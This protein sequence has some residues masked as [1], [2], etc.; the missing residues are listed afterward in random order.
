MSFSFI[1]G[2]SAG[3]AIRRDGRTQPEGGGMEVVICMM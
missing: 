1:S 3:G 2:L